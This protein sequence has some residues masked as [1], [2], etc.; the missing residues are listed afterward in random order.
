MQ[1]TLETLPARELVPAG[2]VSHAAFAEAALYVPFTHATHVPPSDA[3]PCKHRQPAAEVV[4]DED[5]L[6]ALQVTQAAML[7]PLAALYVPAAHAEH[8]LATTGSEKP[9]LH[10]KLT[11]LGAMALAGGLVHACGPWR[12]LYEP[13]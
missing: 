2:H 1:S 7:L 8:A 10:R 5:S 11:V 6:K 3:Y 13:A 4:P 9:A 12:A